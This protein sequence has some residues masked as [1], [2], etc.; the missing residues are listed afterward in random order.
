VLDN[1]RNDAALAEAATI[2]AEHGT[3]TQLAEILRPH[4]NRLTL[5]PDVWAAIAIGGA[6]LENNAVRDTA[7][8]KSKGVSDA[9]IEAL[10]AYV[11]APER[12]YAGTRAAAALA[13][14]V[15]AR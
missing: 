10:R 12:G 13:A 7:M 15:A 6:E 14:L 1:A 9:R 3:P 11:E 8:R 5:S 4:L 2:F